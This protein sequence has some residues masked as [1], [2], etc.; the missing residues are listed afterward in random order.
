MSAGATEQR[1][2]LDV[3]EPDFEREVLARSE[4]VPVVV[5]FWAPW[6]GPCRNLGPLLERLAYEHAGAFVLAK[7]DV[8]ENPNLAAQF[9]VRSIPM[10]LGIRDRAVR[11]EFLGAQPE[12]VVRQFLAAIR[13]GEA[14]ALAADAAE[15]AIAGDAAG[16]EE[17]LLAALEKEPRHGRALLGLAR[18]LAA[19]GDLDGA[20]DRLDRVLPH[21]SIA[22]EAERLAAELRV[23]R[24]GGGGDV[25][26][27]RARLAAAPGD[28]RAHL[29]LGRALAASGRHEEALAELLAA[30]ERDPG[31]EEGAARKAMLDLFEMLG[32]DHPLT[33]RYRSE[34]ARVL[35]R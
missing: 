12:P 2:I 27:L 5:D 33:Q 25:D 11:S 1:W 21:E 23:R 18:L 7:V 8:D 10:V 24:A 30:V 9:G 29:G 13:P 6:C 19:R 22:D 16:A 14:D 26:A 28:V 3:G 20:L 32:P 15:R 17:K 31:F 34:L 35:F 4:Q